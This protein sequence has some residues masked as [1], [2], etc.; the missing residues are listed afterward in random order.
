M[1]SGCVLVE[2]DLSVSSGAN[3]TIAPGSTLQFAA[4]T[5]LSVRIGSTLTAQGTAAQPI[6]LGAQ[7]STPGFW[8]GV[9]ITSSNSAR[10]ILDHVTI[11]Y[12]GGGTSRTNLEL[13]ASSSSPTR[14][15]ISD[16]TFSHSLGLGIEIDDDVI[17]SEYSNNTITANDAPMLVS[18]NVVASLGNDSSYTG[19]T[20][21]FIELSDST[22]S[23]SGTWQNQDVMYVVG[24]ANVNVSADLAIEPGTTIEVEAGAMISVRASGSL[25][26]NGTESEPVTISGIE[27]IPGFWD[28]IN[29]SSGSS[30][31][32][33]EHVVLE[34]GG[35]TL[36][37]DAIL[38]T[39]SS[40]A[41][42]TRL[43]MN[44]VTIR[45]SIQDGFHLDENTLLSRFD[46]ITSTENV[47]PGVVHAQLVGSLGTGLSFTGNNE[48]ALIV[49]SGTLVLNESWNDPGVPF[50]IDN[51]N[52]NDT[53][54]IINPGVEILMES[55]G[56]IRVGRDASLAVAGSAD[57]PVVISGV[58]PTPGFWDGI[59][60]QF[61]NSANN[62]IDNLIIRH[63]GLGTSFTDSANINLSCAATAPTRL[64]VSN[65]LIADSG[66]FG[67]GLNAT[68]N[69]QEGC[70]LDIS[71]NVTFSNNAS[72]DTN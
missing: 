68:N 25:A 15:S 65:S 37:D 69:T 55:G 71:N 34:Y 56:S 50:R 57:N 49:T 19:N 53:S 8:D 38:S 51:L 16:S 22:F 59:L 33:L 5:S 31:N 18:L 13:V 32:S 60:Y 67:I 45:G 4:G 7:E 63:G 27:K 11:E 28:G 48:D 23:T 47:R 46:N 10:N 12:G 44:E 66:N 70:T 64:T 29:F 39:S 24:S 52:M 14:I 20:N 17:L 6:V 40:A 36:N 3:L 35:N 9:A 54:L 1:I 30:G 21:D 43:S 26:V 58:E 62:S 2:R 61:S 72:G 41:S 42:P